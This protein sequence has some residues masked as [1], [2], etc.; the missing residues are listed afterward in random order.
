[1][2]NKGCGVSLEYQRLSLEATLSYQISRNALKKI[3]ATSYLNDCK[4]NPASISQII[5]SDSSEIA[6]FY[7]SFFKKIFVQKKESYYNFDFSR[8]TL[9]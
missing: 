3:Y 9:V 1:M 7:I 2:V 8:K 4:E 6:G 5:N